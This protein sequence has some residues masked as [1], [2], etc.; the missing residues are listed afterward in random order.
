MESTGLFHFFLDLGRQI[1]AIPVARG[2][3]TY[4]HLASSPAAQ[5]ISGAYFVHG[6]TVRSSPASYDRE[7]ARRLWQV[8]EELC[9]L[10]V[11][12]GSPTSSPCSTVTA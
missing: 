4:I 7:A 1:V 2:A 5:D 10:S 9:G 11:Y 8:S 12:A 3:Q 6:R